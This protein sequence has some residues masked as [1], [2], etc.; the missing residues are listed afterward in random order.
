MRRSFLIVLVV[1]SALTG[2]GFIITTF[3]A[4]PVAAVALELE[5]PVIKTA[6][7]KE[8]PIHH[9]LPPG[10]PTND[11]S[12]TPEA[13]LQAPDLLISKWNT[14][15][16]A[17]PGGVFVYGI[18]Y[19]NAGDVTADNVIIT[20]TLPL[21]TTWA[22]DTSGVIP[23]TNVNGVITWSLG[24]VM[25]ETEHVFMV[26]LNVSSDIL[27]G[28]QVIE[29]NCVGISTT[30]SGDPDPDDNQWCAGPV[31]VWDDD[32]ELGIDKWANPNDPTPGQNFIYT[33]RWCNNRGA[34]VGPVWITDT[35]PV[36][37]T[38]LSW[39][40]DQWWERYFTEVS[41]TG[42][43][44]VLYASG[45]PGDSCQHLDLT[46][47]LDPNAPLG[48]ELFNHAI[49][50][51]ADDVDLDN[52]EILHED[53]FVSGP[54]YDAYLEKNFNQ[55][56]PVPGGW[57]NYFL[58]Y[59]NV[60]NMPISVRFTD[61][62]PSGLSFDHAF[63]GGGQPQENDPFPDPIITGTEYVWE[64]GTLDVA[65]AAW[66][67]IQMNI[68]DT[69]TP[70]ETITNC[71]VV[72][73]DGNE[74]TPDNDE[75]CYEVTL[76]SPGPNLRVSKRHEWHGDGQLGYEIFFENIG[77]ETVGDVW[78]TDTLPLS[79]TWDGWWN[80]D[81]DPSRP[82]TFTDNGTQL[83]WQFSELYPGDNGRL[84]FNANLDEPG[85]LL[86]W[87]TN[88]VEITTPPGDIDPGDNYYQD[89]AF[90]GGEVKQVEFWL[91]TNNSS[92]MWGQAIHDVP[93]TVT[94]P[95]TQVTAWADGGCGGCWNIDNVGP[96]YPSDIVIIEAGDGLLP[97]QVEIADPF[98]VEVDSESDE[99]FGQIGGWNNELVEVHGGWPGGYQETTTDS[100][101]N[102]AT[103]YNDIPRGAEGYVRYITG[104]DYAEIIFH[105]PFLAMDL[106]MNV[107]YGHDW[108]EGSYDPGYTVWLTATE[109]DGVTVKAT[110]VLTTGE[111]PWWGGDTGFSTNWQGWIPD[112]PDLLSGDWIY[113]QID[114]GYT[115]TVHIGE[116][117]GILDIDADTVS[118][119]IYS[120]FPELL[121][122]NCG[123]WEENGP[124][125]DFM[126]DGDGGSYFCDFSGE[127][128]VLPGDQI[129]VQYQEPDGDWVINIFSDPAPDMYIEKWAEGNEVSPGGP[130]IFTIFYQNHGDGEGENI[131][132][133]DTLP[134]NTFY[135]SDSS[136]ENAT[137]NGN[138]VTW[139]MGPLGPGAENQFQVVLTNTA[140]AS[141]TLVN[142][143]D[144]S[145][146]YDTND[147]NN[148]AEA[149]IH[150]A[151]GQPD[152]YVW[153]QASPSDPT[154]GETFIYE[155]DY[156]NNGP[157]ASGPVL[158]TDTFPEN[159]S[160]VYWYSE[161]GYDLWDD[162]LSTTDQLTLTAPTIPGYWGDRII[163]RLEVD[164]VTA[165]GTQLTNT[166]AITTADD[167]FPDDNWF[168]HNDVWTNEPRGDVGIEKYFNWGQLVPG[169]EIEY[170][171]H[172][173]NHGNVSYSQVIVTDTLPTGTTFIESW[174]WN[175]FDYVY[176]PPWDIDGQTLMWDMGNLD[177]G[178]WYN[179]DIRV[180][181]SPTVAAGTVLTNCAQ[182]EAGWDVWL[183]NNIDC[184]MDT[185]REQ[186]PNL[187]LVKDAWWENDGQIHYHVRIENVGTEYLDNVWITDTYP[188]ST[189]FNDNWWV[190]HGPWITATHNAANNQIIFWADEFYSGETASIEFIV[191]LDGGLIGQQGL[192][193]TNIV[194]APIANDVYPMDNYDEAAVVSGPDIYVDKWLSGG[195]PE[196]GEIVTFTIEFGNANSGPW[197]SG[198]SQITDTLPTEMTFITTT[199]PWD[200]NESW[201]P[202][203]LPG[204]QLVWDW[205]YM[206]PDCW[207]QFDLVVQIDDTVENGDILLNMVEMYATED[208]EYDYDNN[209]ASYPVMIATPVFSVSKTYE[210]SQVAGTL[211]TYT[212]AV[213]N[214]GD[215]AGHNVVLSDT[216]PAG[217]VY[218]DGD[219]N[220]DGTAVTW[221]YSDIM[222][223]ETVTGWFSAR[224][225]C[226]GT[227][228]NDDYRVVS[229]NEGIESEV[230][231]PVSFTVIA[232][233]INVNMS[234]GPASP[235][236]SETVYFTGTASTNG[237]AMTYAWAFGDGV[238]ATGLTASHAYTEIGE[239]TAVFTATD[240]CNFEDTTSVTITVED[241]NYMV[242]LPVILK[243]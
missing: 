199:A 21:S 13:I 20:D 121:N 33:V 85:E 117:N 9:N 68:S 180:G 105:H 242:F 131:T 46:L 218:V 4:V 81:F 232:P 188:I 217:L 56:V 79:T 64:L 198:F 37:T 11:Q 34:A 31:D 221:T 128:D 194:E 125:Y 164:S 170:G 97:V 96:L 231:E 54:R 47:L 102:F 156:G 70:G 67:H 220:F 195:S 202:Q 204:N 65:E 7:P 106:I 145:A 144:I 224:L 66:F 12:T 118:G 23:D 108:V 163:L 32:V 104:A 100:S 40:P 76:N 48:T 124:G 42:N 14:N 183:D 192:L 197:D 52:N 155:I 17:R 176:F 185:V 113:G 169:E 112:Q 2:L 203:I 5:P 238:T 101:G 137:I 148:H 63:W 135:L 60:G 83:L 162:S 8:S 129:G 201:P 10:V 43:E 15:G 222:P 58:Y 184:R 82:V 86:R 78:I 93:V 27:T 191:D 123:V 167:A 228:T 227:V 138:Q 205:D 160:I 181:I 110:A 127:W 230:G 226:S 89:E 133:T 165:V 215:E 243:P 172:M 99:V 213:N 103:T 140:V 187:R 6:V 41:A 75:A 236:V 216:L 200:A 233:T 92:N 177:P 134:A 235:I 126:V 214:T 53:V 45:L 146:L 178:Q 122:G 3:T 207:W 229:S 109:S 234:Y 111:V 208:I 51:T 50:D 206:C 19:R 168:I 166:V 174:M 223:S 72:G 132:I 179:L 154:P 69:L 136:G 44:L 116:I 107:N 91:N 30:T 26:T 212:L 158:L 237:T 173:R 193:F 90:S 22:G 209:S 149:E 84:S 87:F 190:N 151:D 38:L 186:G 161:N 35:L 39:Q 150:V 175:G 49:I 1:V 62:I 153:K 119:D 120:P 77:N 24:S 95:Y 57:I 219:G 196:P 159:T 114:N 182:I 141:D 189:T 94:T 88:T 143:V 61:T 55:Y 115:S 25:S 59:E 18:Y 130:V 210:S 147:D 239:Y 152:L 71:A 98:N 240:T 73:I 74:E 80:I 28:S 36:S 29:E 171:L 211:V 16:Y 157:V 225:P 241:D 142:Q 139:E